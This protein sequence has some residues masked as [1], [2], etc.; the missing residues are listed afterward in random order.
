MKDF[1]DWLN[2]YVLGI[3]ALGRLGK[4][5]RPKSATWHGYILVFGKIWN[6]TRECALVNPIPFKVLHGVKQRYSC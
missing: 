3:E 5:K 4:Q 2:E 1:S 6:T